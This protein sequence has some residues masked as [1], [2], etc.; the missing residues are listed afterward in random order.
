MNKDVYEH[1]M[2]FSDDKDVLNML[3]VNKKFSDE[4]FFKKVLMKRYPFLLK[5]KTEDVSWRKFY[6]SMIYY[7]ASMKEKYPNAD[8]FN[9]ENIN[10]EDM[11]CF[12]IKIAIKTKNL[13]LI[14]FF[15][16]KLGK[17]IVLS[18][19]NQAVELKPSFINFIEN[20]DF[21]ENYAILLAPLLNKRILSRSLLIF[22][23][24]KY[25]KYHEMKQPFSFDETMHKYLTD[26][27]PNFNPENFKFFDFQKFINSGIIQNN[28][29]IDD[30]FKGVITFFSNCKI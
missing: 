19:F 26:I 6:I 9:P 11:I 20:A 4:S 5:Y 7:I 15:I 3:S 21:G 2:N 10:K 1:L 13:N 12:S 17:D 29:I 25:V 16:E 27:P 14:R 18:G 30:Y 22:L 8:S 24:G 28:L 23:F